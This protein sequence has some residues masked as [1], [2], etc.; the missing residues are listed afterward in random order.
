M[1]SPQKQATEYLEKVLQEIVPRGVELLC[2]SS[3]IGL[4]FSIIPKHSS[5]Y[6]FLIGFKGENCD[7]FR[8]LIKLWAKVNAP[9]ISIHLF[10]PNPK[11]INVV[12]I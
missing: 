10:V 5:D 2:E 11:M 4:H 8:R 9:H 7:T 1:N 12:H 6:K 3:D